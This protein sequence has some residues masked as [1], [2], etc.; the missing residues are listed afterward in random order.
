MR[1]RVL[2]IL[3][4]IGILVPMGFLASLW[5]PFG[6]IFDRA[7]ATG[8]SHILMHAFLY[9]V[10]AFLL[11]QWLR[12]LSVRNVLLVLGTAVAIGCL[13]EGLQ[14]LSIKAEVGWAA[15]GFDLLVD[16]IGA[17]LGLALARLVLSRRSQRG[18]QPG[19]A[20]APGPE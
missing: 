4:V 15:S 18:K 20:G 2:I 19:G 3:W 9:L 10:L 12:P 13:Q 5:K 14:W 7:F 8:W 6:R 1:S 17:L 11:A 16:S